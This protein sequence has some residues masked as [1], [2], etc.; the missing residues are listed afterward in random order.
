MIF[1]SFSQTVHSPS[2]RFNR[3]MF[4]S[5]LTALISFDS[6]A[7]NTLSAASN[8]G[9]DLLRIKVKGLELIRAS[10]M[11]E[12]KRGS[13]L[14]IPG[15]YHGAWAFEHNLL[16]FFAQEG[17]DV[18][19]MSLRGHGFS[20]GKAQVMEASFDD[21]VRDVETILKHIGGKPIVIG[22]SLGGLLVRRVIERQAVQAA[23]LL[24]TPTPRSMR[25]GA[26]KLMLNFPLAV[27]KFVLSGDPDVIYRDE[28]VVRKLLFNGAN[29]SVTNHALSMLL[30]ESESKRIIN[31]VQKLQFQ[32][33]DV[34]LF[35]IAGEA[36][37]GVPEDAIR[38]AASD[39]QGRMK[40]VSQGAHEFFLMPSWEDSARCIAQWL[41]SL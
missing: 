32:R 13:I 7:Q 8:G 41:D 33:V 35:A 39:Y 21:Y 36:D 28:A 1:Q 22:H 2:Y 17:F 11:R 18:Y 23:V 19:A 24:A 3:R 10:S 31:D 26:L 34:P 14:L 40:L 30:K 9:H 27:L 20:D 5:V 37:M 38:E 6:Q 16:P 12:T 25:E 29:D 4:L 15:A